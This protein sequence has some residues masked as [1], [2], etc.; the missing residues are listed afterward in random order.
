METIIVTF[1]QEDEFRL[2]RIV[3]DHDNGDALDFA[4]ELLARIS[5]AQNKRVINHLDGG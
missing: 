5:A 1:T 3:I 4:R 2:K